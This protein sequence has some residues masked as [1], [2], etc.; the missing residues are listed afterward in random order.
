MLLAMKHVG[1]RLWGRQATT[2]HATPQN[3]KPCRFTGIQHYLCGFVVR[4]YKVEIEAEGELEMQLLLPKQITPLWHPTT[5]LLGTSQ[6]QNPAHG[7]VSRTSYSTY[8][9]SPLYPFPPTPMFGSDNH[10][11]DKN[12]DFHSTTHYSGTVASCIPPASGASGLL[13]AGKSPLTGP[14][15]GV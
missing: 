6:Y 12:H 13:N 15:P 4:K 8:Y 3:N 7:P 2:R 10:G 1:S 5:S 11:S 9:V 14:F